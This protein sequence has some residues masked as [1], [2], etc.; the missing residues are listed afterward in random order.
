MPGSAAAHN[1]AKATGRPM[2]LPPLRSLTPVLS[3]TRG[4]FTFFVFAQQNANATCI[5]GPGFASVSEANSLGP[6][7]TVPAAGI[8]VTW[9]A[10][11]AR[12]GRA[13]SFLEG[14]IGADVTAVTLHLANGRAVQASS[15]NG[16]FVAWWPGSTAAKSATVT[17]AHGTTTMSLP[18]GLMPVCPPAPDGGAISCAAGSGG[19][20]VESGAM[21]ASGAGS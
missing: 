16:W 15:E 13:Y 14:H 20:G 12:A 19:S 1:V 9:S 8:S 11:T 4:P 2:S 21:S 6:V 3:D 17:T 18:A 7:A 10:H 5:S